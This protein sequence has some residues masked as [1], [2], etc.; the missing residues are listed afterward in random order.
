MSFCST[1]KGRLG[2]TPPSAQLDNKVCLFAACLSLKIVRKGQYDGF[3]LVDDAYIYCM[4]RLW[5]EIELSGRIPNSIE[6]HRC[7]IIMG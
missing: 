1:E 6:R 3:V 4:A 2:R 5:N 7:L